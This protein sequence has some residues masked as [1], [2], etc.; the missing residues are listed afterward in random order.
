MDVLPTDWSPKNTNL[1]L[2]SGASDVDDAGRLLDDDALFLAAAADSLMM[3]IRVFV[4]LI[5]IYSE[6]FFIL[7]FR[8][9]CFVLKHKRKETSLY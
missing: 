2:A 9:F 7:E 8:S 5:C 6:S 1:Y 3:M 4:C